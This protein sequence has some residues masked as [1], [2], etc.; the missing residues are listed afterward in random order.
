MT[1]RFDVTRRAKGQASGALI[2]V[3]LIVFAL[4]LAMAHPAQAHADE[5]AETSDSPLPLWSR[6]VGSYFDDNFSA[7]AAAPD[8]GCLLGGTFGS[9][10]ASLGGH[11]FGDGDGFVSG[12]GIVRL[13]AWGGV[14][15]ARGI[16]SLDARLNGF[17][18]TADGGFVAVGSTFGPS[19]NL[20][21]NDW[22]NAGYSD[23]VALK[24]SADGTVEWAHNYGGDSFEGFGS[25]AALPDGGFLA[26]G[27][28]I[29]AS[30]NLGAND[31]GAEPGGGEALAVRLDAQGD[32]L[33]ARV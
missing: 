21:A 18:P 20:G 29:G 12:M 23:A 16:D 13:D 33:W 24:L 5:A 6:N 25:V 7:V 11:D 17:A 3:I 28:T 31:W 26:V 30:D 22:G 27:G 19:T 8:G 9:G 15:W 14:V 4:A 10:S 1:S 32:V 2:L